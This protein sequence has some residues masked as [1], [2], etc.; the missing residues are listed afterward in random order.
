MEDVSKKINIIGTVNRYQIKKITNN[1]YDKKPKKRVE[2]EK[3]TFSEE[4][5]KYENQLIMIKD[6]SNNNEEAMFNACSSGH[7]NVA[8]FLYKIKP[9]INLSIKEDFLFSEACNNGN[10]SVVKWL[11]SILG[12]KICA[13][14]R[15][16]HSICGACF[17]G[18]L[19]T[20]KWLYNTFGDID[21]KV[22]NDYCFINACKNVH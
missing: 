7:L 5:Y 4:H 8:K 20:A 12:D 1:S 10:L 13:V 16:E 21:I 19:N 3:W 17:Y 14:S 2:S 18:H 15:Y 22:D 11:Y 9:S 6:I